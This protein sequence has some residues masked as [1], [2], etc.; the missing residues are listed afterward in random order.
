MSNGTLFF[1]AGESRRSKF[2]DVGQS[3]FNTPENISARE[4]SDVDMTL[5][6]AQTT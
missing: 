3:A 6:E 4:P 5:E 1:I 2:S